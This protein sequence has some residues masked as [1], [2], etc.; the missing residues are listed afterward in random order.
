MKLST[1]GRYGLK[2]MLD[3]AIHNSEGQIALKSIAERQGVSDNYL[4]QIFALLRKA[5][6]VKS[7]RGSQGGYNLAYNPLNITVGDILRALE[8][9]LAPVD[10]VSEVDPTKCCRSESCV[11]KIIWEKIRDKV[12]EV[13]DSITLESLVEDYRKANVTQEYTYY[14]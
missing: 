10:C 12:N 7:I 1:K 13:V 5:G 8:G 9:S 14:I 6:L 11:T 3:L 2:A 4:E